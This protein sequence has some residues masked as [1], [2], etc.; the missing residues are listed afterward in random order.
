V[1]LR[2]R[3]SGRPF[4]CSDSI[5]SLAPSPGTAAAALVALRQIAVA[6]APRLT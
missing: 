3:V 1:L 2:G 6:A 4:G 5:A